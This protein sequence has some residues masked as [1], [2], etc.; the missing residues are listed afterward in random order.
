ME[1]IR[2]IG[3]WLPHFRSQKSFSEFKW[4]FSLLEIEEDFR[5]RNSGKT[6]KFCR[7]RRSSCSSGP[8]L[9]EFK[10][11]GFQADPD[12]LLLLRSLKS[13]RSAASS[14]SDRTANGGAKR[15]SDAAW[16]RERTSSLRNATDGGL[17]NREKRILRG[18]S[19]KNDWRFRMHKKLRNFY[20][21]ERNAN[22]TFSTS[23]ELVNSI[24]EIPC[25]FLSSLIQIYFPQVSQVVYDSETR[26]I[27]I[28]VFPNNYIKLNTG[29]YFETL[30][31]L[32]CTALHS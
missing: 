11:S 23:T 24:K 7:R 4:S 32:C 28:F 9:T 21:I 1:E 3:A 22:Y 6:R 17:W 27:K 26:L 10:F 5:F 14:D 20:W 25:L 30:I 2:G 31:V 13:P 19:G 29:H 8:T 15:R 16:P 18:R 12:D